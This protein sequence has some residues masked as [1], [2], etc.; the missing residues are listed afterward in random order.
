ML[1]RSIQI[2]EKLEG[3]GYNAL[4]DVDDVKRKVRLSF[5]DKWIKKLRTIFPYRLN[6]RVRTS[7][8]TDESVG[9]LFPP[10]WGAKISPQ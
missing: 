4:H 7:T 1:F 10:I 8:D 2:L 3:N 6:D 5:E 9:Y